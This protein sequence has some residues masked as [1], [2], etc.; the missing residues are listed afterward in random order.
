M[1]ISRVTLLALVT[2]RVPPEL[3][4]LPPLTVALARARKRTAPVTPSMFPE[5][6]SRPIVVPSGL[7]T[8]VR[9]GLSKVAVK[10][11]EPAAVGGQSHRDD[12][13]RRAGEHLPLVT[14]AVQHVRR[15]DGGGGEVERPVVLRRSA[16]GSEGEPEVADGLVGQLAAGVA[17]HGLVDQI[18]GL[19][20]LVR[21]DQPPDLRERSRA[22]GVA[23]VV[24]AT[25]PD[26]VLIELESL[27]VDVAEDHGA[28][29]AV[30]D[31]QRPQPV[32]AGPLV[33]PEC[34]VPGGQ[35]LWRRHRVRS[36]HGGPGHRQ[37]SATRAGC[38]D[39]EGLPSGQV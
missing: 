33:V 9:C 12:L 39:L 31:R 34:E 38:A 8:V 18:L 28:E 10:L 26:G 37:E 17:H 15:R 32:G 11:I 20:P 36:C 24:R 5:T 14:N 1:E 27:G 21:V 7:D 30:A 25:G 3:D 35:H 19:G 2:R 6:P 16:G 22:S 29:P 13:V 4:T 23:G